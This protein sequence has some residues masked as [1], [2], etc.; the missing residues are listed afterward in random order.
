MPKSKP[1][2]NKKGS[3]KVAKKVTPP[4]VK[5]FQPAISEDLPED[6]QVALGIKRVPKAKIKEVDYVAEL[7]NENEEDLGTGVDEMDSSFE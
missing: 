6:V 5:H 2:T 1:K 4:E 3:P 7:E